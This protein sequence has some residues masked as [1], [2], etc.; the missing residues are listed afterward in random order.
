MKEIGIRD[1]KARASDLVRQVC[2]NHATYTITRRGRAVGV[3]A[4]ADFVAPNP[5]ASPEQA[6]ER[7]NRLADKLDHGKQR[8]RSAVRELEQSRR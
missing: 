1:L 8:G 7:L 2:E 3:L 4:P 6:W 5:D